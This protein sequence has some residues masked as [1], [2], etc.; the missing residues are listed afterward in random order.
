MFQDAPSPEAGSEIGRVAGRWRQTY[1]IGDCVW[2]GPLS[3]L[4]DLA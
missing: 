4:D 3:R 2:V 1:F